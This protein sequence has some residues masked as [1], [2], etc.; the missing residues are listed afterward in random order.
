M[1]QNKVYQILLENEIVRKNMG[2]ATR[3]QEDFLRKIFYHAA[4]NAQGYE[5]S[6]AKMVKYVKNKEELENVLKKSRK[7]QKRRSGVF[8]TEKAKHEKKLISKKLLPEINKKKQI[9]RK[10]M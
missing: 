7:S 9:L 8:R 3:R 6:M 4:K 1:I 10:K 2:G 5:E